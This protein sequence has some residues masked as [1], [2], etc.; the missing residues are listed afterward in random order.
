MYQAAL[1]SN[2]LRQS[3]AEMSRT[4]A[5]IGPLKEMAIAMRT[6]MLEGIKKLEAEILGELEREKVLAEGGECGRRASDAAEAL[7]VHSLV[8]S[9]KQLAAP[10]DEDE[11]LAGNTPLIDLLGAWRVSSAAPDTMRGMNAGLAL[12]RK[13]KVAD[14]AAMVERQHTQRLIDVGYSWPG[15]PTAAEGDPERSLL[16]G[17][18]LAGWQAIPAGQEHQTRHRRGDIREQLEKM[19]RA[20]MATE[21][22]R[23]Y[24]TDDKNSPS[25]PWMYSLCV[26][27]VA[28]LMA[29][30][31][32]RR[33]SLFA[34]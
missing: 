24:V 25:Y 33:V 27:P 12:R 3:L 14:A 10:Y 32:H 26:V 31:Q 19:T 29:G 23:R 1:T 30:A 6:E 4:K 2:R 5:E 20:V 15:S 13:Q 18:G 9:V 11:V 16:R 34:R 28:D 21:S 22:L 7:L 17:E 8:P